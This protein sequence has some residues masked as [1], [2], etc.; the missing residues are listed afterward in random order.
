MV[1][2]LDVHGTHMGWARA[3]CYLSLLPTKIKEEYKSIQLAK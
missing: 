2:R 3:G 1:V